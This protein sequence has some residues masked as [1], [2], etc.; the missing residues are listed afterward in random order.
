[1][2]FNSAILITGKNLANKK[3]HVKKIPKVPKNKPISV[4]EPEYITQLEGK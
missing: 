2:D 3:K 4:N 1:M